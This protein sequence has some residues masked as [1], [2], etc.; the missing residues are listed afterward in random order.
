M[1]RDSVLQQGPKANFWRAPND[2]ND[3]GYNMPKLLGQWKETTEVS[4]F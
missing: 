1:G 4:S 2:S 3:Y